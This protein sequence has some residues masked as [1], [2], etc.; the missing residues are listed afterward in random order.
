MQNPFGFGITLS[1]DVWK[2]K[3]KFEYIYAQNER[4]YDGYITYGFLMVPSPFAFEHINSTST[5]TAYEFSINIPQ[6]FQ[7]AEFYLNISSGITFDKYIATRKGLTSGKTIVFD[8]GKKSGPFF[9]ISISKNNIIRPPIK[10]ELSYKIKYLSNLYN[11]TDVEL[12]FADIKTVQELQF[13][14]VYSID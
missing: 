14:I 1:K 3:L 13:N 7:Y 8:N 2:V 6:V 11:A 9:S 12:P 4:S 5:F 10:V